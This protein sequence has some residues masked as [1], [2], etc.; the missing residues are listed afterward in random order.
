MPFVDRLTILEPT[1]K[2]RK[3]HHPLQSSNDMSFF[4]RSSSHFLNPPPAPSRKISQRLV[5]TNDNVD[6]FLSSDLEISFA[7][8]VSLNSPPQEH[9]SLPPDYEP[10]DISPAPPIKPLGRLMDASKP[11][12]NRPRAFTSGARLFGHDI[13]NNENT[14]FPSPQIVSAPTH[15]ATGST[16]AKRT[17]RAA[18]PTEWLAAACVPEPL[19]HDVCA[20]HI[21]MEYRLTLV[22]SLCPPLRNLH[23]L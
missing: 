18:L 9:L 22:D 1:N 2:R 8:N 4:V 12:S 13:S 11:Q 7:S 17:Q 10:M 16:S 15:K 5:R 3:R 14:L 19:V 6:D 23:H 20:A 21:I